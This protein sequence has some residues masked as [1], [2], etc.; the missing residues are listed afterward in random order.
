[1]NREIAE[2]ILE[3]YGFVVDEAENGAVAVEMVKSAPARL[4]LI[5][6]V[7]PPD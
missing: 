6:A 5:T 3:G 1:M 7:G 2:A 4:A